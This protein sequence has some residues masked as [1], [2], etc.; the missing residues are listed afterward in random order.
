[1][2]RDML[3][4]E[5]REELVAM[6]GPVADDLLA[7]RAE[8][9]FLRTL[10]THAGPSWLGGEY[11][12]LRDASEVEIA[13][14]LLASVLSDVI[15]LRSRWSG[16][17]YHYRMVDEYGSTLVLCRKTSVRPLTMAQVIE[18]LE[19]VEGDI[20][21]GGQGIV[22]CWW[23]QQR[24]FGDRLEECTGFAWVESELY[25]DLE[26]WY[27]AHARAWREAA[28]AESQHPMDGA[29]AVPG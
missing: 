18:V 2:I 3:A 21:T 1:M 26:A 29:S 28:Q 15:S 7:E 27:D 4:G 10:S 16:G 11:L 20:D 17:R 14:V 12:P 5:H 9:A 22:V 25:P 8:E 6:L 13:R 23:E 24:S 19:T